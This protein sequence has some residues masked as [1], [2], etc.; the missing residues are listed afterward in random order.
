M[1]FVLPARIF[2]QQCTPTP[3]TISSCGSNS[4]SRTFNTSGTWNSCSSSRGEG[5]WRYTALYS[6]MHPIYLASVSGTTISSSTWCFSWK[7]GTSC[8]TTGWTSLGSR[9]S[10]STT[11]DVGEV[12][13]EAGQT[14]LIG[15]DWGR[16]TQPTATATVAI[17]VGCVPAPPVPCASVRTI[18]YC[19]TTYTQ[20][21]NI[22]SA[23]DGS[24]FGGCIFTGTTRGENTWRFTPT[25]SGNYPVYLASIS[26]S[27][28][29][30]SNYNIFYRS[31]SCSNST[32][33]WTCI[34]Y[35]G[36]AST[37]TPAGTVFL[38]AGTTYHFLVDW[39]RST[40]PTS[41]ATIGLRVG[42]YTPPN[43]CSSTPPTLNICTSSTTTTNFTGFSGNT[44]Y[45]SYCSGYGY[46]EE[47]IYRFTTQAAGNYRINVTSISGSGNRE[48]AYKLKQSTICSSS[49]WSCV[50]SISTTGSL[51]LNNLAANT[52]YLLM[53][54]AESREGNIFSHS[55]NIECPPLC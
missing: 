5:T 24:T 34:G 7:A 46:G 43:P 21:M 10:A 15:V 48:V 35:R 12:F 3:T 32:S 38:E 29:S 31:G 41:S 51:N 52:T 45:Q 2:A 4:S 9:T 16:S 49:G 8:G 28:T 22:N 14:Y 1:F 53:L 33:G 40:A 50:G 44:S 25:L 23:W 30:S 11:T 13:M 37:F 18:T 39:R 42:C 47:Y 17:R 55:F 20:S 54:D 27:T 36:S 6:G 19:G 26:G